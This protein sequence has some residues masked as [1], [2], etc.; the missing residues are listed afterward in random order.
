MEIIKTGDLKR[1]GHENTEDVKVNKLF[2]GVFGVGVKTAYMWY[3]AGARTLEDVLSGK[4]GI[5]LTAQQEIGIRYYDD[6]NER[7]PRS[8]VTAIFE[9]I[10]RIAIKIDPELFVECMGSYRRGS[11]TCGDIDVIIT[12]S[13][14]DGKTHAG[15]A[16]KLWQACHT[17]GIITDD[18]VMPDDWNDLELI[19]RGL[20]RK[21]TRSKRR[22]IDFLSVPWEARGAALLYYTGDDIFNRSLRLK[23]R[24]N[25]MSLNQRG[26]Y[27]GVVRDLKNPCKKTVSGQL[28]ASETEREILE[29]LGVPWQEPHERVRANII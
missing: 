11:E 13:A 8:E 1:I 18:L 24:K 5:R 2:Q 17:Q 14:E 3:T 16:K 7:M 27:G 4:G 10:K 23:A 15:A 6:I 19:Y 29:I 9:Q 22:R 28:L 12:R 26:L 21:D 25:G 20:C